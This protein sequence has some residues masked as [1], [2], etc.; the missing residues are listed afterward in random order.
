[1]GFLDDGRAGA[2]F[3]AFTAG[4]ASRWAGFF[5]AGVVFDDAVVR[6]RAFVVQTRIQA[7]ANGATI[8]I[9][10]Q[11]V[12]AMNVALIDDG[13]WSRFTDADTFF[14][15]FKTISISLTSSIDER[16]TIAMQRVEIP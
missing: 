15:G 3:D 6:V 2:G 14:M 9:L 5:H 13:A 16:I 8:H 11:A 10:F 4:G 1:M 7:S 12:R